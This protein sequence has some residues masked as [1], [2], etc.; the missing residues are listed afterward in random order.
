LRWGAALGA[1]LLLAACGAGDPADTVLPGVAWVSFHGE[2]R[3]VSG[4]NETRGRF[5]RHRDGSTRRETLEAGGTPAFITIEHRS[6]ARFYSFSGGV[7]TSQP[8]ER[9]ARVMLPPTGADFPSAVPQ[10]GR[11]AGY[12]VVRA[13]TALGTVMLRA[14][15]LNYFALVEEHPYPALRVEFVSVVEGPVD[16]ALFAPPRG[17]AVGELP[18]PYTGR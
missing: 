17:T 14:P 12:R 7:W 18:W 2:F 10:P 13:D 4:T 9:P 11:I 3:S 5:Y 15:A 1:A 16:G 6:A 8:L